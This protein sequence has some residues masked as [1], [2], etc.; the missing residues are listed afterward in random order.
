MD[1]MYAITG[2]KGNIFTEILTVREALLPYQEYLKGG[3][4]FAYVHDFNPKRSKDFYMQFKI[5][6]YIQFRNM[7]TKSVLIASNYLRKYCTSDDFTFA[8]RTKVVEEKEMN[9]K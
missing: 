4:M 8:F 1:R 7:L 2:H 5:P 9:L 6:V 3:D